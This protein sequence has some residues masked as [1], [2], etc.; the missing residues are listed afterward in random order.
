MSV[1]AVYL[2]LLAYVAGFW[3]AVVWLVERLA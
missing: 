1:R 2:W 3:L